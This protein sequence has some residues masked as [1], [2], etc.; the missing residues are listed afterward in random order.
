MKI[1]FAVKDLDVREVFKFVQ[2]L[3]DSLKDG[4]VVSAITESIKVSH[5]VEEE[6]REV[7]K[8]LDKIASLI[9]SFT[10]EQVEKINDNLEAAQKIVLL[11]VIQFF[12]E[13]NAKEETAETV[14]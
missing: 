10:T 7:N 14:N 11:E 1:D 8:V 4:Q 2:E 3:L 12:E 13:N 9:Q 5:S 6:V